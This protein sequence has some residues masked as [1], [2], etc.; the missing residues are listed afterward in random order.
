MS[1]H[2][3]KPKRSEL[4]QYICSECAS[5]FP[6]DDRRFRCDCGGALDLEKE[7][8]F[9]IDEI[10]RRKPTL[11]RYREAIPIG[12][13]ANIISF[14][15]GMTPLVRWNFNGFDLL[16]KVDYLFP[17]GS[18]KDRGATVFL[19]Y[20]NE[21]GVKRFIEDSS[22][23]AGS[24]AAAYAARGGMECEIYCPDY[25]SEGKLAQVM[26]YGAE[27]RK[28]QG[29]RADTSE[30]VLKSAK[31]EYYAS[32]NW[33]PFY[34][35]G[36]KTAAYEIAEQL[37]WRSPDNIVCPLGYGG[38]ILGLFMGFNE[39]LE[40]GLISKMPR[41]FGVQSEACCPVYQAFRDNSDKIAEYEQVNSTL[42]EGVCAAEP[43]R[44]KM[45]L[46]VFAESGGGVTTVSEEEII[47][48][49]RTLAAQGF[50]VEPTSA[51][52]VSAIDHFQ[53]EGM[54]SDDEQT[55]VILTGIGLKALSDIA[56]IG[57]RN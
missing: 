31:N 6:I 44:G 35:E 3:T 19:S 53:K 41:L 20:L 39:L 57:R 7:V 11:W 2:L 5:K 16:A 21:I 18:F 4:R 27:L 23:N 33:N 48:G 46:K 43:V 26:M 56:I 28:I 13:D 32:H 47:E 34:L 50:F 12:D 49:V 37:G 24:A 52:V 15:E 10:A 1:L 25:A 36:L 40:H 38:Y 55:V 22:G 8:S 45:I 29:T 17:T 51:V 54:L 30:A 14:D 42:A 9:P